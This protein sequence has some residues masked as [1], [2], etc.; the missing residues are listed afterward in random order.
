MLDD[1]PRSDLDADPDDAPRIE[2]CPAPAEAAVILPALKSMP[3]DVLL[4]HLGSALS[5]ARPGSLFVQGD[6]LVERRDRVGL[7][8]VSVDRL[9]ALI[10]QAVT[11]E[12]VAKDGTV[13]YRRVPR[14]CARWLR[15]APAR[16]FRS[17]R[18]VRALPFLT[19]DMHVART[20][21]Y[22]PD[23]Q[24]WLDWSPPSTPNE[25]DDSA[26]STLGALLR[27]AE[28]DA[29]RLGLL[30]FLIEAVV[31]PAVTGRVP[32][33]VI[34]STDGWSSTRDLG[35]TLAGFGLGR[36]AMDRGLSRRPQD[37]AATAGARVSL[38]GPCVVL[39]GLGRGW[40][41]VGGDLGR[42]LNGA[43]LVS[44]RR[45]GS[46]SPFQVDP[47]LTSWIASARTRIPVSYAGEVPIKVG[48]L[49]PKLL[50]RLVAE[51]DAIAGLVVGA[52]ESW[53]AAGRPRAPGRLRLLPRWSEIVGAV[54][55]H[56]L[57]E[58]NV[59][60]RQDVESWLQDLGAVPLNPTTRWGALFL[61]WPRDDTQAFRP[62]AAGEIVR[63]ARD[64]GSADL[65]PEV[66]PGSRQTEDAALG[67]A[68]AEL[69]EQGVVVQGLR[70][71]RDRKRNGWAY[72]PVSAEAGAGGA[73]G[74]EG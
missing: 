63:L 34:T 69:V 17:I 38:D 26:R 10:Q 8:P 1:P 7:V 3:T 70:L 37:L 59:G 4:R 65:I 32:V 14:E 5:G 12:V 30:A 45:P 74:A 19:S 36:P 60:T 15:S 64:S 53:L 42:L 56:L 16:H 25:A 67:T 61:A 28:D 24:I 62:L 71:R 50:D 33:Y 31:R 18:G 44:L 72:V 23:E 41:L 68:L 2:P 57:R 13:S 52:V 11:V 35:R 39:E 54:L 29:T 48:R 40:D 21:G 27:A 20:R 9:S 49:A 22:Y 58:L 55:V 46:P 47:R 51:Q 73:G 66:P 43:G 6:R